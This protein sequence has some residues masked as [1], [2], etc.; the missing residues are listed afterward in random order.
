MRSSPLGGL[1]LGHTFLWVDIACYALGA[2]LGRTIDGMLGW[3][4]ESA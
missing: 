4:S 2:S 1:A 3:T